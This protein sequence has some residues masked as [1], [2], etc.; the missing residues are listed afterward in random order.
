MTESKSMYETVN[1][2][3]SNAVQHVRGQALLSN[4]RKFLGECVFNLYIEGGEILHFIYKDGQYVVKEGRGEPGPGA[5]FIEAEITAGDLRE[6]L[7]GRQGVTEA[8]NNTKVFMRTVGAIWDFK[9]RPYVSL[10]GSLTKVGQ[11]IVA[12][13]KLKTFTLFQ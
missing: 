1:K 12:G 6:I 11:D 10:W 5:L 9:T 13:E 8:L 7:E 3:Y 4:A 2:F